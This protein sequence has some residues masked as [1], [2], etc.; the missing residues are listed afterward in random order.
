MKSSMKSGCRV[1]RELGA[2]Q[3]LIFEYLLGYYIKE[4]QKS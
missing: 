2:I 1:S 3:T 4:T